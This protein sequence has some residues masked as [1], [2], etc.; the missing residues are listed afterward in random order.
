MGVR[1]RPPKIAMAT[2]DFFSKS[3]ISHEKCMSLRI[4]FPGIGLSSSAGLPHLYFSSFSGVELS[5]EKMS[6][7]EPIFFDSHEF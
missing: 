6:V 5:C 3:D 7:N 2:L 1:A 4:A